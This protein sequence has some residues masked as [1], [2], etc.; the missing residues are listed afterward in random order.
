VKIGRIGLPSAQATSARVH[1]LTSL[2]AVVLVALATGLAFGRVYLGRIATYEMIA[3][4]IASGVLAWTLERR[5]LVLATAVSA[6]A[7]VLTLGWLVFPGSIWE[8]L[9]TLRTLH[10]IAHAAGRVGLQARVQVSPAPATDALVFAGITAVWAALFSC[11]AL[12]FRAGSPLLALVPPLSLVIFADS[13]LEGFIKPWYGVY[14]LVAGLA[15]LYA[16]SLRRLQGWGAVW[17][18]SGRRNRLLSVTGRSARRVAAFAVALAIAAPVVVPGFGAK[19]VLDL[20][21]GTEGD[22]V[23]FSPLVSIASKLREG[24]AIPAFTVQ[25]NH[26]SYWRTGSA[27]TYGTMSGGTTWVS[28]GEP[29]EQVSGQTLEPPAADATPIV[30]R[31]TASSDW[32]STEVPVAPDPTSVSMPGRSLTWSAGT[33]TLRVDDPLRQGDTYTVISTTPDPDRAALLRATIPTGTP[34][35]QLPPNLPPRL[36]Q[37][38][39]QWTAGATNPYEQVLAIQRHLLSPTSGFG[40]SKDVDYGDEPSSLITFLEDTKMGFCQQ[41]ASAMAVLLRELEIPARVAIG[42]TPGSQEPDHP[43]VWAVDTHDYHAW[44]E[45]LFDGWGWLG[46][47]ATPNITNPATAD[48]QT[49]VIGNPGGGEPCLPHMPRCDQGSNS[50][51]TSHS[52]ST[53]L[54]T[55]R[56]SG[57]AAVGGAGASGSSWF[58]LL[59]TAGIV[60]LLVLLAALPL[61]LEARR[62]R[63]LRRAVNARARILAT[64]AV[65]TDRAGRLGLPRSPGETAEEYRAGMRASGR[66]KDGHVDRLTRLVV[67][68]AYA[69]TEPSRDDALDAQA[70]ADEALR[71]L[72]ETTPW[73]RRVLGSYVAA[74]ARRRRG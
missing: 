55:T 12:A 1:R 4:G 13:V 44:V 73:R 35:T 42:F 23:A 7:L 19:G 24:P 47:E 46:F 63:R 22:T 27:D 40:Y 11:H 56:S 67:R 37:I 45:V 43:N 54:G 18:V 8:G 51:N 34:Y 58:P 48:Y 61:V 49:R 52:S 20:R 30:Q 33:G 62:R 39:E 31:F 74:P 25:T 36:A 70:D 59:A 17:S 38:A 50:A 28:S 6:V 66:V 32:R 9:T 3:V 5:S 72:R 10:E 16:D 21:R 64:Y 2:V 29:A 15:V 69:E 53:S 14:F 71:E 26:P 60:V 57:L 41:Y 65:F 68:A